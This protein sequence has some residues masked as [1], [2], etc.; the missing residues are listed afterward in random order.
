M[1]TKTLGTIFLPKFI[2]LLTAIALFMGGVLSGAAAAP[3][4][5]F[6]IPDKAL[7]KNDEG[8]VTLEWKPAREEPSLTYEL[9]QSGGESFPGDSPKVRYRG[10][11]LGS[12]LTGYAEGTYHF[13]VRAIDAD[14]TP[15][16][17]SPSVTAEI[18]YREKWQVVLLL[19]A[20]VIV[21]LATTV[22]LVTC[23]LKS[24]STD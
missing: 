1:P 8:F 19:T 17:W 12:V 7:V 24:K 22:T 20:G 21:F 9:Q 6:T 18:K 15:G 23:H 13:R 4:V 2:T 5:R 3:E 11:D 16:D 14:G 10:P